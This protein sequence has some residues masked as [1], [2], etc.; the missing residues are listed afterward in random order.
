MISDL[1]NKSFFTKCFHV[2]GLLGQATSNFF[3][4]SKVIA[5]S[6]YSHVTRYHIEKILSSYQ[7]ANQRRMFE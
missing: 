1:I 6:K 3:T 2:R 4:D 5:N 7:A